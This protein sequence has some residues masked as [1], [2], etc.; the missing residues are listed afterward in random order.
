MGVTWDPFFL[1]DDPFKQIFI[2]PVTW[3]SNGSKVA[4][5][6]STSYLGTASIIAAQLPANITTE[7]FCMATFH[8]DFPTV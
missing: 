8:I 5:Q 1:L 7:Q 3:H 2:S 4:G 6:H